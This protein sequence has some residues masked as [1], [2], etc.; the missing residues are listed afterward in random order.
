LLDHLGQL[1][2][3]DLA[4][5]FQPLLGSRLEFGLCLFATQVATGVKTLLARDLKL[6]L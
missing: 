6:F 5:A 2:L 3:N 4:F 1:V